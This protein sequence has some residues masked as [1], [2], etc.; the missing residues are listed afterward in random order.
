MVTPRIINI[1][2]VI[3]LFYSFV[4]FI[5]FISEQLISGNE[6]QREN[7]WKNNIQGLQAYKNIRKFRVFILWL[8][9][10]LSRVCRYSLY[11]T[12]KGLVQYMVKKTYNRHLNG[13]LGKSRFHGS[14]YASD[15][16][17]DRI[18][19]CERFAE[20]VIRHTGLLQPWISDCG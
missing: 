14:G 16:W 2:L 8:F 11:V 5:S 3:K 10:D 12:K 19:R 13:F 15:G 7:E 6:L 4:K 20:T 17:L 18:V 9:N 1:R